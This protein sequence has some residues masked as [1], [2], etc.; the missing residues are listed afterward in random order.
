MGY[1][2]ALM[3][4]SLIVFL[5]AGGLFFTLTGLGIDVPVVKFNGFEAN[6]LPAGIAL[7]LVAVALAYFWRITYEYSFDETREKDLG[8]GIERTIR[9]VKSSTRMISRR[10]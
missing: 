4:W 10:P 1:L 8:S 3:K 2:L 7:L 9:S 5:I 6:N